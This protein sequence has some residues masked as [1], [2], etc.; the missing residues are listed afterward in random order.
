MRVVLDT[1]VLIPPPIRETILSL[2]E[3]DLFFPLWSE[4][5][6]K[7]WKFF[8]SKNMVDR[9]GSIDIEIIL[10]NLKW[11]DSIVPIDSNLEKSLFLPDKNDNHVLAAAIEGRA[12]ILLTNNLKDFPSRLVARYNIIP[13]GVDSFLLELY[14]EHPKIVGPIIK[15]V[16]EPGLDHS[17]S[18]RSKKSFLKR[19]GLSRLAKAFEF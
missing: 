5:I 9:I 18:V 13:R 10:M 7:E 8:V 11:T 12:Q 2:A 14:N 19:Y 16:F 6:L 4:N 1:C 17:T 3:C 15:K